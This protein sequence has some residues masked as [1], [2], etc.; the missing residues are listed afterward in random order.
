M[1]ARIDARAT[2]IYFDS[3]FKSKAVKVLP[4]E[5]YV[6]D[7][8][9]MITTVLGSC[10][11]ACIHDPITRIGGMNHF[12]LPDGDLNSP[13]SATMRYGAFAMEVLINELLKAG[14][15]RER[16]QAKVFGGGAVLAAMQQMNI[17]ERNA[18]F[19]LNYLKTEGIPIQAQDLGDKHARR[20]NYFPSDGR[21]MVRKME[22]RHHKA[23]E[24]IAKREQEIAKTVQAE[25]I[26]S[27]PRVERF[28]KPRVE[29]FSGGITRR[30]TPTT[31]T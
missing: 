16:L 2:R 21:V 26:N 30:R 11:A 3:T 6:T 22:P 12:M 17:G 8:D 18:R 4:N 25:A 13:A 20:I 29:L 31:S 23:E 24:L 27:A 5:Y 28:N 1:T 14:A 10:V 15:S 7:E 19:V 9:M